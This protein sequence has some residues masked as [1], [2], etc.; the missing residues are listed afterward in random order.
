MVEPTTVIVALAL[1]D[2]WSYYFRSRDCDPR[3]HGPGGV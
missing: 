1:I 2:R 3:R